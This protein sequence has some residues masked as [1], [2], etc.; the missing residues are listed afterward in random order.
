[1]KLLIAED[2]DII[3]TGIVTLLEANFDFE[4]IQTNSCDTAFLKL[5]HAQLMEAPFDLLISDLS[6][7][8]FGV[9]SPQIDSGYALIQKAKEIQPNLKTI[10]YSIEDKPMLLKSLVEEIKVDSYILKGLTSLNELLT[11][12]KKVTNNERYIPSEVQHILKS[13]STIEINDYDIN[14]LSLLSK[15]LTQVDISE[16]FKKEQITPS[17]TSAIEKK[18]NLLK[19]IFKAKNNVH[20]VSIAK[21]L[22][23]L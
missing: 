12:I 16:Y 7:K 18:I 15:G 20:L 23:I 2:L 8:T 19:I 3:N 1:M 22:S 11:A 4:I 9:L 6:F 13:D 21:D 14:L 10:V 17:S 5:Q